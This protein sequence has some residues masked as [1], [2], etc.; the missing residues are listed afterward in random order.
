MDVTARSLW[1]HADF[2]KLWSGQTVS[3]LGSVVTRT[4]LPIVAVIT[5]HA[6]ALQVGIVAA[7]ASTAVLLIGLFAGAVVDRSR[8]RPLM[9]GADAI[10]AVLL[11]SIPAAALSGTLR[12]EQLYV[13]AFIEAALGSVF[14]IAYR[15]YLPS[16]LPESRLLEGNA[17]IGMTSAIAEIGGPGFAG[18]LVQL[19]TA[20]M[21]MVVDAVSY[22][23]SAISIAAIRTPERIV[24]HVD[25]PAG[26]RHRLAEGI[27]A[28]ASHP[29]LRPMALSILVTALF[30]NFFASLYTLYVLDE[31]GLSP[32]YLGII[33]S[34]G[35]IGSLAATGLVRP[36]T[37]RFGIGPA[38]VWTRVA[39]GLLGIL[40]PIAGG[41]PLAAAAFLFVPQLFGDGL[42]TISQIDQLT[43]RQQVTPA[44]VLG[45][46][47]GTMH[48]LVEGVGPVGAIAGALIAEAFGIRTALWVS[49]LGSLAGLGLLVLSPLRTLR[50]VGS[51]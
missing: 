5:L 50:A 11:L 45:R 34:A 46:V 16:L 10:R 3:E 20:P 23:C 17:K 31:L 9:I 48:V 41:P 2:M 37:R 30:G 29:L 22:V 36:I 33:I 49:V 7:S 26:L 38:I 28:V 24:E 4:A 44:R 8:R 42:H 39:A 19:I 14:D 35:G 6:N 25:G 32:L 27:A 18:A 47:N 1:R 21:A 43:L 15:T 40:V 51:L 12:I 13:V